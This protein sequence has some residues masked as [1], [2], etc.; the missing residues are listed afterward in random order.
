MVKTKRTVPV[1]LALF[2]NSCYIQGSRC[3]QLILRLVSISL[4]EISFPLQWIFCLYF[5]STDHAVDCL[6]GAFKCLWLQ[7]TGGQLKNN[8]D[9]ALLI[10]FAF[11]NFFPVHL[12]NLS[13][14]EVINQFLAIKSNALKRLKL[15]IAVQQLSRILRRYWSFLQAHADL[16]VDW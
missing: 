2:S 9:F 14:N 13:I 15:K 4:L 16:H 12:F 7:R 6:V 3:F 8:T 10:I 1:V 11:K 5:A